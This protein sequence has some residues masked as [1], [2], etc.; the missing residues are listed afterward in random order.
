MV[1]ITAP[2][3]LYPRRLSENEIVFSRSSLRPG[4]EGENYNHRN[5]LKYFEDYNLSLPPIPSSG[6]MGHAQRLGKIAI[7]GQPSRVPNPKARNTLPP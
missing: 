4:G 1:G 5:T 7:L 3:S 2:V 6:A